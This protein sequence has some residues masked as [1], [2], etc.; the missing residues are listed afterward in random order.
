MHPTIEEN[1]HLIILAGFAIGILFAFGILPQSI[2]YNI[3]LKN[4]LNWVYAGLMGIACFVYY[5]IY[6]QQAPARPGMSR[7]PRP[8]VFPQ[9]PKPQVP[10]APQYKPLEEEP[11]KPKDIMEKVGEIINQE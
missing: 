10:L 2:A 5:S 6:M 7:Y 8:P 3:P 1:K 11:P 4:N 9:Y